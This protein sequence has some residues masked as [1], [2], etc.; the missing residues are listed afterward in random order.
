[1]DGV[2]WNLVIYFV[3]TVVPRFPI[4]SHYVLIALYFYSISFALN[5]TLVICIS[6]P[7]EEI[8]IYLFLILGL[9]ELIT[10]IFDKYS[11]HK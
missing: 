5:F 2:F 9:P 4:S 6:S 1:M 11:Y 3:P 10:I 8:A 7:K